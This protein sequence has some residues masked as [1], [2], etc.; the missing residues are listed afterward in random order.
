MPRF[1]RFRRLLGPEPASDVDAEL[2][3]HVEMRVR[4][5]I[6]Q[7]MPPERARALALQRFGDYDRSRTECVAITTRRSRRVSRIDYLTDLRQ[8]VGYALR[9]LRRAP[10]FTSIAVATLALGIGANSAIFS[11]V[12]GVLLAPLPFQEA[13]RL[14]SVGTLYPDG[15]SYSVSAPDFMS[16]REKAR[17]LDRIEAFSDGVFTMLGAGEPREVRGARVSDGLFDLLGMRV[18]LGRSFLT[19][20]N[21]PGREGIAVLD[22]GFWQRELGGSSAA[23]GRTISIAGTP[24]EIVGVLAPGAR[25]LDPQDVYAPLAY[26]DRFSAATA[27]GRRGEFLTVIGRGSPG[28]TA[29][30]V[31]EDLRRIGAELQAA[32]PGTNAQQT[33]DARSLKQVMVGDVRTPLLVLLGAVALVLLVACANVANLLLARASARRAELAVRSALGAGRTRLVRQLLAESAL[34]GGAGA[35][36]GLCLAYGATRALVAAQPGDI[37]RLEEIGLNSTVVW[38]TLGLGLVSG[39]VFGILPALHFSG[40]GLPDALR[41][42]S[43]SGAGAAGHRMRAGL[44]VAE[45][46]LA[47]VLLIGAGLL[48]R[49][50]G[51]MVAFDPGFR[52]E[53]ALSLRVVLQ[54]DKYKEDGPARMRVAQFEERLGALPGVTEVAAT[55]VLPLSGRGALVGFAIEGA[56]PP[57]PD[58]NAEIALASATPGFFRA[59]GAPLLRGRALRPQDHETAPRV[60][61]ANAAAVRQWFPDQDPI[62]RR[63]LVNDLPVEVVGVVGDVLQ[64]SPSRPTLPMLYVPFAQRTIRSVKLV[65]RAAGDPVALAAAARAQVRQLDPDLAVADVTPLS[66]LVDRSLMRPRFYTGLLSLFAGVALAL[67]AIGVFGVMSY[68]VAERSREIGIRMALGADRRDVLRMI[69]GRAVGLALAGAVLGIAAALLLGRF[70][71]GQLFG[72]SLLDPATLV[73]VA[74]VLCITAAVASALPAL[75]ALALDPAGALREG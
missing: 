38:L 26:T 61:I 27:A 72:V 57:P 45:M 68:A 63:V 36:A 65:I 46:A 39:L 47:V 69:V 4:E 64:W 17:A 75:R 66:A 28:A 58:V 6:D 15:T 11:V 43:R 50:F 14:Y 67:A 30:Q 13:S 40:K 74:V 37:P 20:D 60:A 44:V 31:E 71:Q 73:A 52:P 32:F 5:L 18:V 22:H 49:S 33:F 10:V 23:I 3:F 56:P 8:D 2:S 70:I 34:L 7:G 9:V 54:S 35:V 41:E 1:S 29:P 12:H 24:H 55:S 53:Q 25:L 19:G 42:S 21:Q 16:I 48:I 51:R 62:G 59:I